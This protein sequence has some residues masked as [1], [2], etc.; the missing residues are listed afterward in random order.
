MSG[1][2]GLLGPDG[3]QQRMAEI[4]AKLD[5]AL[6]PVQRPA[7]NA[8]GMKGK[9]AIPFR[10]IAGALPD[11]TGAGFAPLSP[12]GTGTTLESKA[13]PEMRSMIAEA[14]QSAGLDPDLFDALV[15]T[16]SAYDPNARSKAGAMGLTQLMPATAQ[17]LGV[18]N[19]F[20]P[21]ENLTGGAKYLAQL[22]KQFGSA[23]LALA[24]YNAG[25]NAVLRAGKSIPPFPETQRYVQ[26]IMTLYGSR[27]GQ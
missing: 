12:L 23:P 3:V 13:S 6:G 5:V 15:S 19:P 26:K 16:E 2:N 11:G 17:S 10:D 25:P 18:A 21:R 8:K 22:M 4:Q 20:D 1:L 27:K 14:A 24:A 7:I 9:F